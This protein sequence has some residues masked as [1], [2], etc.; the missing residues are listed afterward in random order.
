MPPLETETSLPA[1][2]PPK[3]DAVLGRT[4]NAPSNWAYEAGRILY[5]PA[6]S[7]AMPLSMRMVAPRSIDVVELSPKTNG[8]NAAL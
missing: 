3:P 5:K 1:V 4:K 8:A 6:G 7:P 2:A